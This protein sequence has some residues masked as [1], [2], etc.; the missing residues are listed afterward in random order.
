M[1]TYRPQEEPTAR[2]RPAPLTRRLAAGAGA[3]L[4]L[5]FVAAC[6][7]SGSSGTGGSAQ[8]SGSFG[9]HAKGVVNFW[10]RSSTSA[11]SVAMV[12]QFNASHPGLK[13][14]LH[15]MAE[16]SMPTELATAIRAGSQ[17][18]LVG[19]DDVYV[20]PFARENA[21]MNLTKLIGALPYES[22][23]SQGHLQ[24]GEYS[25][26]EY[27]APYL[28]DL[29]VLWYNKNLFREAGLNPDQA[30]D[31]YASI[32]ADAQKVSKLGHG[33]SGFSFAGD[34]PGCLAFTMLPEIW[35]AAPHLIQGPFGNQ[36]ANVTGNTALA[37]LLTMY[38]EIWSQH[39][40]PPAD[41][42]QAGLTWG[43]D[44]QSGKIGILPGG[45]DVGAKFTTAADKAEFA[46]APLPGPNGGYSTF[47][48]GDDFVIPNGAKNS[49]GAWEFVTWVLAQKQQIEFPSL[50]YTPVRTDVLTA[51][52]RA[53]YPYDA[54][55]LEA[56]AHGSVESTLAYDDVFNDP[57]SPWDQ[58]FD[59]AVYDGNVSAAIKAGQSGITSALSSVSG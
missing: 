34:C 11:V 51:S 7:S 54:V 4:C 5:G 49:S 8:G 40:A 10:A 32:L 47:D 58:M 52:Y 13:V 9:V 37:S 36:K 12:K 24:L 44:F 50:G 30:P 27:A 19:L 55:A 14:D 2:R 56:L 6:G 17:P 28:A 35:P 29:S 57:G 39:L 21:L 43:A 45:Y 1:T 46:D 33:I 22:A 15:L 48:G 16:S 18:D 31:S 59:T 26:S 20:P 3:L 53:E 41:Q 23:L 42:T 25:G 38:H